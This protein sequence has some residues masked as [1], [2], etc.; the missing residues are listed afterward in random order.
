MN[1]NEERLKELQAEIEQKK[2]EIAAIKA[3]D[4][5]AKQKKWLVLNQQQSKWLYYL[6]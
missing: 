4:Q 1:P 2:A 5:K 6:A 3:V